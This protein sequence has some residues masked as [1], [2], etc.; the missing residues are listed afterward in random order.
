MVGG[1][2]ASCV[3]VSVC[4]SWPRYVCDMAGIQL[5]W[6][7]IQYNIARCIKFG[8]HNEWNMVVP[9]AAKIARVTV[10]FVAI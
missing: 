6:V 3:C 1:Q 4:H 5:Y 7:C 2:P 9:V 10:V 8:K